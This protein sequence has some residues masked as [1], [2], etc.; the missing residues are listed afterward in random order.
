[1][2]SESDF[3]MTDAA[4]QVKKLEFLRL[5]KEKEIRQTAEKIFASDKT[6]AEMI[7]S[8]LQEMKKNVHSKSGLNKRKK[9]VTLSQLHM[10]A[11]EKLKK[12]DA[13]LRA[14]QIIRI[15]LNK[16]LEIENSSVEVEL[17]SRIHEIIQE[18]KNQLS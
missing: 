7:I 18:F 1:M 2:Q 3:K 11:F 12:R 4:K 9:S 10:D 13:R 14:G 6:P 8:K 15:A 17:E 5:Q 16:F